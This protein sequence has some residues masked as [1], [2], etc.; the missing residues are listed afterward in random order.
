MRF[1]PEEPLREACAPRMSVAENLAFRAFDR[2]G[3]DPS[4]PPTFW[5]DRRAMSRR[6][7][8]L[9]ERFKVKTA[10]SEAPIA[11]LSRRQCP[12]GGPGAGT[13][14]SGRPPDRGQSLLRARFRGG[15][16][17]RTRI[18][19]ARNEGAAVLLISED[20]DEILELS[21]RILVMSEGR[22]VYETAAAQAEA[23]TIGRH[24]AG[25]H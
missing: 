15:G 22:L 10:S 21:D 19:T 1:I 3:E 2:R 17:I 6:A 5:L 11:T 24:M 4:G 25:H 23:G 9:I 20:L 7:K 13:D 8:D 16:G 18:V 14:R 12:A